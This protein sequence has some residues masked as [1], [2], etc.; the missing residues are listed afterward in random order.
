[1]TENETTDS[2]SS[3]KGFSNVPLG[4]D[5][6]SSEQDVQIYIDSQKAEAVKR[7]KCHFDSELHKYFCCCHCLPSHKEVCS[8]DTRDEAKRILHANIDEYFFD[9][10][11]QLLGE[12]QINIRPP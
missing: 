12:L 9:I 7:I 2:I 8:A 5:C 6:I 3:R 10:K 11:L 1:M 4:L